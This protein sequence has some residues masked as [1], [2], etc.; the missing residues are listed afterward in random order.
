MSNEQRPRD[1]R[2]GVAMAVAGAVIALVIIMSIPTE[3]GP[4]PLGRKLPL[5]PRA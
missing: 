3:K 5:I 4:S 1:R 2:V